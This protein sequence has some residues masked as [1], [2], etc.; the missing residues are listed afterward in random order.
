MKIKGR[1]ANALDTDLIGELAY[2]QQ[3]GNTI[4]KNEVKTILDDVKTELRDEFSHSA[5][6]LA[7]AGRGITNSLQ[8]ALESGWVR[9][10]SAAQ[11][12]E[13]FIGGEGCDSLDGL[14]KDIRKEARQQTRTSYSGYRARPRRS[15]PRPFLLHNISPGT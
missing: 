5:S 6:G 12:I 14:M 8:M 4:S 9:G 1:G 11:M 10:E 2:R 13:E 15:S 3:S 7:N